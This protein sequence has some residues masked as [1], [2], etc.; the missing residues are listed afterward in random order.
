VA[1]SLW[2]GIPGE[3]EHESLLEN[4]AMKYTARVSV[5]FLVSVLILSAC[6]TVPQSLPPGQAARFKRVTVFL[7]DTA[8]GIRIMDH[9]SV[10][11]QVYGITQTGAQ[12]GAMGGAV[13][14]LFE[15][16]IIAARTNYQ[17]RQSLGGD[18]EAFEKSAPAV[19]VKEIIFAELAKQLSKSFEVVR[20]YDKGPVGTA[21]GASGSAR[22]DISLV[23]G[24]A[25]YT[26]ERASVDIDA[27]VE[28]LDS[29]GERLVRT[30]LRSDKLFKKARGLTELSE[31]NG[32]IF[33]SDLGEAAGAIAVQI[34]SVLGVESQKAAD[35]VPEGRCAALF[36]SC[37]H[38]YR[39]AQDC[40]EFSGATRT[41][42]LE[43]LR[44][45]IAGTADGKTVLIMPDNAV[46]N[47]LLTA[48]TLGI[49]E[50]KSG[51]SVRSLK[52]VE[53][54]LAENNIRIL[55]RTQ[56]V[57]PGIIEGFFLETDKDTYSLLKRYTVS[58]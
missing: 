27:D 3:L 6:A 2:R 44:L 20:T 39:L 30:R 31:N 28:V 38:P 56:M 11:G 18:P 42:R 9:T 41:I 55:K 52:A 50:K 35:V 10:Q 21:D 43:G 33:K 46:G 47:A 24:L 8:P 29:K 40:S 36:S 26:G 49:V 34:A 16:L 51:E 22:L 12:Y 54:V 17:I 14:G 45:K 48:F 23:Y 53:K 57:S 13:G 1:Y 7:A 37:S 25:A 58:P 19:P 32:Q 4:R 5:L 15:G